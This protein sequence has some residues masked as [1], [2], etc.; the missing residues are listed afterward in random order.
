MPALGIS[1]F[2]IFRYKSYCHCFEGLRNKKLSLELREWFLA[3]YQEEK[4][5]YTGVLNIE[6]C[7]AIICSL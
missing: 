6:I 5:D 2:Q 3:K 4:I 7:K 1:I